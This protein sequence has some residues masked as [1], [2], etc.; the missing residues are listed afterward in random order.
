MIKFLTPFLLI[1]LPLTTQAQYQISENCRA[2]IHQLNK[3]FETTQGRL[4][5]SLE[6]NY[7]IHTIQ[8]IKY[9][10]LL[11]KTNELFDRTELTAEGI[12]VGAQVRNI[13]TL[14]YPLSNLDEIESLQGIDLLQVAGKVRPTLNR[15]L[16][17]TRADSVH[18]GYGLP[19]SY[20]GK[21]VLIGITDWGFDYSSPMFYDTLLQ[22]TRI[23]AAW[24]QFKTAGPTPANFSYGTEYN[25][26][27]DLINAGAD[28][29][30][31]YSY[32]THGSHV[33]GIA[34]GS[35]VGT[36]YRGLAF[37]SQFLFTTFLV[38]EGAV[39]DAWEWMY[40]KATAEGK[41]LVINMSWGLYHTG[42]LDGT[43]MLSQAL[44]NY[45]N[46]GVL[47]VTSGGNNGD[48]VFHIKKEFTND[49]LLSRVLFYNNNSLVTL[50]GQSIHAW[51]DI[52]ST[53]HGGIQVTDLSNQVVAES[54]WY[55]T[56]STTN[57]IDTFL[58]VGLGDTLL[59]NLSMDDAYPTNGRPQMRLRINKPP[60]GYKVTIKST[61]N[62]GTVHYWN[63]TE[64]TSDVGNWGMGFSSLGLGYTTGDNNY[65]IGA[66]ACTNSAITVAAYSASYLT[67]GGNLVGGAPAS[68]SSIGP[69]MDDVLKPDISAPGVAVASSISSYTDNNFTQINVVSFNGRDYPFARFSGTSMSSPAVA[70]IAALIFDAN[71]YLSPQQ[72]KDIL[73]QTAREDSYTGSIPPNGDY[74]WGWG[75]VNAYAAIQL[76]LNTAGYNEFEKSLNWQIYPNPA[77]DIINIKGLDEFVSQIQIINLNGQICSEHLPVNQLDISHL[78]SGIYIFKIIRGQKVEQRKFIVH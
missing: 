60:L 69:R 32:A 3:A 55:A 56:A 2:D 30:N 20:T 66:P 5:E 16:F 63:V 74:K 52:G 39:L 11:A 9:L 61:A 77:H 58:V 78:P 47:F 59:Y 7:P 34:G 10:S 12:I 24:D 53:F 15:V 45:S 68:F 25:T 22:N 37:E 44:D 33:A 54:P 67:P 40:N 72:V 35:G 23:L 57:Y 13:V 4:S 43:S 50:W 26:M 8:G 28:T 36:P 14:K 75:K 31:I 19:E 17:D 62:S 29:A 1:I 70:G 46:L 73:I 27:T 21:N 49:T 41:R 42:A 51:G 18:N 64:L 48:V 71:P 65:G 38:D 6:L 76:A